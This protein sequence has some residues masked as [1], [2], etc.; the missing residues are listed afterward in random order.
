MHLLGFLSSPFNK[1]P[2]SEYETPD[3]ETIEQ[4]ANTIIENGIHATVRTPRGL[5]NVTLLSFHVIANSPSSNDCRVYFFGI[6]H[7]FLTPIH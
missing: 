1:W 4:F 6:P 7:F 3:K 5:G 2:G